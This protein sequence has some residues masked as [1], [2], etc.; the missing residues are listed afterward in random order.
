VANAY[1]AVLKAPARQAPSFER[2]W[3]VWA[4]GFGGY[5]A[6]DGDTA[7]GT[8]DLSARTYGGAAG[9]D[10][11]VTPGTVVGFALAGG[12]TSWG[13]AEGLGSGRSDA[14]LAGLYGRTHAGAA[15]ASAALAFANHWMSTDRYA[16]AGDHLDASFNA[17]SYGG[18]IEG[19]Y[20][21]A[22]PVA[23]VTPY[24]ALQAQSFHT[25]D[26]SE[27]DLSAGGFGLSYAARNATDTRSE[28]G[29][30]FDKR[31]A[32]SGDATLNLRAALAWAHDWISDPSLTAT[33]QALPGA[34][35]VVNGAVPPENSALVSAGAEL[36]LA[37]G[38]SLLAK[39]DGDFAGGSQTYSGSGTL[40]YTW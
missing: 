37:N 12:G 38:L 2:R 20:R 9:L 7:A 25:P 6:T 4:S 10:Y 34:S 24:A 5:N 36:R 16:F 29:A 18:R 23:A 3:R 27:T 22:L 11:R 28:L 33:F 13:L 14:F 30:R 31:M 40:R 35:F 17:Q 15:Y 8:H 1:A 21:Y 39:F 19:G 26:Y 32:V